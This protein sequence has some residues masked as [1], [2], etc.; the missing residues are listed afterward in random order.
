MHH[1]VPDMS[2]KTGKIALFDVW[3]TTIPSKDGRLKGDPQD[4]Q[5]GPVAVEGN[6]RID[7]A[8]T[9]TGGWVNCWNLLVFVSIC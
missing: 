1:K 8:V 6:H 5:D 3:K 4:A 2:G 9:V 7:L